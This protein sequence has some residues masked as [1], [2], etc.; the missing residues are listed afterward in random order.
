MH[1]PKKLNNFMKKI[2]AI[3]MAGAALLSACKKNDHHSKGILKGPVVQVHAGK[4]W[5]WA[6]VN[7]HGEV[8]KLGIS[9]SNEA[10]NS[11]PSGG[12]DHPGH[13]HENME[14]NFILKFHP[15]VSAS[16][17]FNHVGMGWNPNGHEPEPIYGIPHFDFHYYMISPEEVAAI[18]PFEQDSTKFKDVPGPDY[19]PAT[20]FN[21][22]GGV[23]QMGVHWLDF[24]SPELNGARFGQ[25]FIFGTYDG[26]VT[27]FEPMIT[28]EF[29]K[30]NASFERSIPQPAKVEKTGWYPTKLKLKQTEKTYDVVLDGFVYRVKS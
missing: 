19:L 2:F 6:E 3:A 12:H 14:N 13:D 1:Q 4:S 29:M 8:Q 24:T 16:T 30:A 9:I 11:V 10:M 22:G 27:F 23:P 5:T 28:L 21:P 20:Y 26:D 15:M 18:P 7:D 17:P 25:T